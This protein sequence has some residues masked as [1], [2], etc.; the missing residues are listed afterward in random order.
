MLVVD[1]RLRSNIANERDIWVYLFRVL[2][3]PDCQPPDDEDGEGQEPE[4]AGEQ[5][6]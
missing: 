3:T 1:S 4:H 6:E 2:W 5:R